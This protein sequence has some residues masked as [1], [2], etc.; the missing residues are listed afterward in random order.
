MKSITKAFK[1][2][3]QAMID[4]DPS[5]GGSYA[6]SWHCNVAM[7]C[8]DAIRENDNNYSHEMALKIGNDAA[9]RF[10]RL[11]FKVDTKQ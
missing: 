10:M 3:Q 5:K 8:Y 7:S 2:I 6:H 9:T 11:C 1:A 4:D